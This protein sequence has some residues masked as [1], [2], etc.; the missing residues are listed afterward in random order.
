MIELFT[1][2][3]TLY[4]VLACSIFAVTGWSLYNLPILVAGVKAL[5]ASKC[6][7]ECKPTK[8]R[9]LPSISIIVP[10]KDEEK[11]IGRLL[12]SLTAT[13]YPSDKLEV[14]V[15][16]DGSTDDTLNICNEF[17]KEHSLNLKILHKEFSNGKPSALNYGIKHAT[18]EIIG[19]LDADNLPA[20]DILLNVSKYFEDRKVAAVQGRTLSINF[21]HN[22]LTRFISYEEA[23][24]CEAYLR[25][26]DVLKLFINLRGSCQFI[27]HDVLEAIGGFD[28]RFLAEDMELSARMANHRYQIR[29]ASNVRAWQECPSQLKQLLTQRTRWYRGWMEIALRYG[30]LM[31]KPSRVSVDAEATL[32]GPF[33]MIASLASYIFAFLAFLVPVPLGSP[34]QFVMQSSAVTTTLLVVLCGLT[35][36]WLSK[37]RRL[38]NLLWLPFVYGYWCLQ[39]FIALYAALLILLRRPKKW[40]KTSKTGFISNLKADS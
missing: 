16:E 18:G 39:A 25:G 38:R 6:E 17:A 3:T 9:N 14:I 35:L 33:I 32:L 10:V 8:K 13:D 7:L 36:I 19:I 15:V 5:R 30:R 34:L 4:T 21:E 29:Y 11:V 1:I 40:L 2:I 23:A 22:M 20:R 12:N 26:K 28:E 24:W 27:R 37:P 31:A